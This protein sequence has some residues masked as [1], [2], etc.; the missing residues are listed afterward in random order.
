MAHPD[1]HLR[2]VRMAARDGEALR[3]VA[4]RLLEHG[5]ESEGVSLAKFSRTPVGEWLVN[6]YRDPLAD[7]DASYAV[8]LIR[9]RRERERDGIPDASAAVW[10]VAELLDEDEPLDALDRVQEVAPEVWKAYED[11]I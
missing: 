11:A 1:E 7:E 3:S 6:L 4:E 10:R 9:L 8:E 2:N 5:A